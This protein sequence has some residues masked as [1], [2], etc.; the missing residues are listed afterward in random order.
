MAGSNVR[1]QAGFVKDIVPGTGVTS[2]PTTGSWV[3]KDAPNTGIQVVVAGTGTVTATVVIEVSNDGTHAM[4]TL[5][6]TVTLS[7][8]TSDSDGFAIMTPWK[9]IRA[10]VTAISGTN[11]TV[12]VYLC[13]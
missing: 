4:D 12:N 5:A 10:R 1:L 9:F 2:A 3:Y 6:G 8:T 13:G 11:A 7:G